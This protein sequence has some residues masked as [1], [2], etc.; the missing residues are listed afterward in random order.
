MLVHYAE[1]HPL[2]RPALQHDPDLRPTPAALGPA[3][4]HNDR[5]H[6]GRAALVRAHRD[7]AVDP[8]HH[9]AGDAVRR[10]LRE[11]GW[12]NDQVQRLR[13]LWSEG[14]SANEIGRR[15]GRGKDSVIGKAHR[16][17]MPSRESPIRIGGSRSEWKDEFTTMWNAGVSISALAVRFEITTDNVTNRRMALGLPVRR[18]VPQMQ[19]SVALDLGKRARGSDVVVGARLVASQGGMPKRSGRIAECAYPLNSG[20]PWRFCC[21][22][23]LPNVVYCSKH[24][25][26]CSVRTATNRDGFTPAIAVA[27]MQDRGVL[28]AVGSAWNGAEHDNQHTDAP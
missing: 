19:L 1:R 10:D 8:A 7:H 27:R 2:G 9:R 12:T 24:H 11:Q 25:A 22:P 3:V 14:H 5:H 6:P 16:L 28:T 23:T 4:W 21:E 20:R 18:A 13:T 17:K 26:V 15:I